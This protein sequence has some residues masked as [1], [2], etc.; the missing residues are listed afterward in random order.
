MR[1]KTRSRDASDSSAITGNPYLIGKGRVADHTPSKYRITS[2]FVPAKL[3][4]EPPAYRIPARPAH[5]AM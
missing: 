1:H 2:A 3:I 4:E 5:L